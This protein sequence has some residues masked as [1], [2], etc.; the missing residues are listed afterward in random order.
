MLFPMGRTERVCY[1]GGME[2][3]MVCWEREGAVVVG[4]QPTLGNL[5]LIVRNML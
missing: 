2:S 4:L 5:Q 1:L 3:V